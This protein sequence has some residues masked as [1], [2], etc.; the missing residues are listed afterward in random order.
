MSECIPSSKAAMNTNDFVKS[1][2]QWTDLK[3]TRTSQLY[4]LTHTYDT[5][6]NR[7]LYIK[8]PYDYEI[9]N[10]I[11]AYIQFECSELESSYGMDQTDVIEVLEAFYNCSS[12]FSIEKKKMKK[13]KIVDLYINWE[14]HCGSGIQE[15]EVL[16]RDGMNAYFEKFIEGFYQIHPEW[17]PKSE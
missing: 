11:C 13:A 14:Q 10:A 1:M 12:S 7:K 17:R 6:L 4:A 8:A 3:K 2:K 15:V 16:K 9:F 5:E